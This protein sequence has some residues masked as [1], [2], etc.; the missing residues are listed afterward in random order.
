MKIIGYS[1]F[2]LIYKGRKSVVYRATQDFSG[3]TVAIKSPVA[4][5][6]S[7]AELALYSREYETLKS[8][9]ITGIPAVLDRVDTGK[10]VCIMMEYF[11]FPSLKQ[12]LVE[13]N[14]T[15]SEVV[16]VFDKLVPIV[17]Q[18]HRKG[19][20]HKDITPANILYN[21]KTGETVLVDFGSASDTPVGS[22][23]GVGEKLVE[24][25]IAYMSPEQTGRINRPVDYRSDIYSLGVTLYHLLTGRVPFESNDFG[26]VIH[27]HIAAFPVLP[28]VLLPEIPPVLSEIVSK[29]MAKDATDRYQNGAGLHSDINRCLIQLEEKGEVS[30]FEIGSTDF[31]DQFV[32]PAQLFGRENEL[33]TLQSLYS[34]TLSGTSGFVMV[35]GHSGV[36]KTSL[37]QEMNRTVATDKGYIT[38]GKYDQYNRNT[39]YSGLV[40]AFGLLVKQILT[41]SDENIAWWKDRITDAVDVNGAV[42]TDMLPELEALIGKQSR[43]P[44]LAPA[45]ARTLMLTVF[46]DFIKSLGSQEHPL[47]VFLD[48]LQWIDSSS[49]ALIELFGAMDEELSILFVGAYRSNEV[50]SSHPLATVLQE[51]KNK[52]T[53]IAELVLEQLDQDALHNF[54]AELLKQ[55]IEDTRELASI[56]FSKAGGNPLFFRT[57]LTSLYEAGHLFYDFDSN[58]WLWDVNKIKAASYADNVVDALQERVNKLP[59]ESV[60]VLTYAACSGANFT[61]D[62]LCGL[63][64]LPRKKVAGYLNKPL[65]QGLISTDNKSFHLYSLDAGEQLGNITYSFSHDRIQQA[66]YALLG[67]DQRPELHYKAGK[68]LAQAPEAKQGDNHLFDVTAHMIKA[69]S[70]ICESEERYYF[71]DF[72]LQA[73]KK[74]K[75]STAFKDA[76]DILLFA[77][78][79]LPETSWQEQYQLTC[80]IYFELAE[81]LS[82]SGQYDEAEE[83]Y[84]LLRPN[85]KREEDTLLLFN[86]LVKQYHYQARFVE[87]VDVEFKGLALMGLNIPQTDEELMPYFGAEAEKI[88]QLL[89]GKSV[90]DFYESPDNTDILFT[91]KLELLFDLFADSYLIGRG[92][93]CGVASAV[94]ARL[95]MEHGNNPMASVSYINYAS[96]ICAMG[97]DYNSG[98]AFG[99]LAVKLAEKYNVPALQNYTYHVFALAANHW[100]NPLKTSHDYWQQASKLA[101]A[102]GSPYSGY[103]FLQLAHVLLASGA[104][105]DKVEEQIEK[106]RNFLV[107]SGLDAVVTLLRLIVIQPVNHLKGQTNDFS[108]LDCGD[109]NT[110]QLLE[111]F[112][113]LPFF[114]GSLYYS[115]LR[116]AC[117]ANK[118]LSVEKLQQFIQMIDASQQGQILQADS[119]LYYLLQLIDQKDG[120]D[121]CESL[122]EG[123]LSKMKNWADHCSK[124]FAHK[125]MLIQVEHEKHSLPFEEVI[126]LY[127]QAINGALKNSFI[128][129]AALAAEKAAKFWT[130]KRK[131]NIAKT[132]FEQAYNYYS[133]WGATG[134]LRDLRETYGE[135]LSKFSS[136]ARTISLD[137]TIMQYTTS[138]GSF[139]EGVDLNAV[140]KATQAVSSHMVMDELG[141]ALLSIAIENGGATKGALL[142][143]D[144]E[145]LLVTN[146]KS[147][148]NPGVSREVVAYRES[149][150]VPEAVIN[151]VLRTG[152]SVVLDDALANEQF[153]NCTYIHSNKPA[154]LCCLPIYRQKQISGLIY[155]ENE[156]AQGVFRFNQLQT[157][158][159]VAAQ[160]TISIENAR[161]YQQQY[162]MTKNLE[163]LVKQRTSELHEINEQ[164][165][166][167]NSELERLSITDQLTGISNRRRLEEEL[168]LTVSRCRRYGKKMSV[169]IFDVDNFK[170]V[171]D[172]FGHNIGDDVL[173]KLTSEVGTIVRKTDIFGRWGGEEFLVI[174]PEFAD[175][176]DQIAEKLRQTMERI[177]HPG[178]GTVTASLGVS[179]YQ[180]GDTVS[181]LISRA[182]KALYQAKEKGRNRVELVFE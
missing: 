20:H 171:N 22:L 83:I 60:H 58:S 51:M 59:A 120:C 176:A 12:I 144:N 41:E 137:E 30:S 133:R 5:L 110:S 103:V 6:P 96:T 168:S 72:A 23:K 90:G 91:R 107:K 69:K 45:E 146:V 28:H 14:L 114:T 35:S 180:E 2:E 77:Q 152:N 151:Y 105:L 113:E 63:L 46:S 8:L 66:C 43:M 10:S 119:Y 109:F 68:M 129:D 125:Y 33:E 92:L 19:F 112:E 36:G 88:D 82:L 115:M 155:L 99:K 166:T 138:S 131:P 136:I 126:D 123:G 111:Q 62:F 172:T 102:S 117:L 118:P 7:A 78:G 32:F 121:E 64:V 80:E 42:M 106:S 130:D 94:M 177:N 26:E 93:L 154:S 18:L 49:L 170:Y 61:L 143:Y 3:K 85:I 134:K 86:I 153:S 156:I 79:L 158:E 160:A 89:D 21:R 128:H 98:F 100:H 142:I 173:V 9:K 17:T 37:V 54:L 67:S 53:N 104:E 97:T 179:S 135:Y 175:K 124:N 182:D 147:K 57:L 48:D 55:S 34:Q 141:E 157:L 116:V 178:V 101:L 81:T 1:D 139:S 167:K 145:Q 164:L 13:Q 71:S 75:S 148:I 174:I 40:Q 74:A 169:V 149:E 161:V 165:N 29:C 56:I 38:Y 84:D 39:P 150:E 65:S 159:I 132:Y 127:D 95:S 16:S 24:G 4:L 73:G 52:G 162:K 70:L 15:I 31:T 44:Q 47:V 181:S 11:D 25:T 140:I 87:A 50:A 108:T 27:A 76:A 122:I 163:E